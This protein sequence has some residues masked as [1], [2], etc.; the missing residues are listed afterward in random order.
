MPQSRF[1]SGRTAFTLVE[2]L[3]VISIIGV[4][5]ALLLPAVNAARMA[6]FRATCQ[7]RMKEIGKATQVYESSKRKFP[8]SLSWAEATR[9]P[10][11]AGADWRTLPWTV[12][13][14]P[15]LDQQKVY[16]DITYRNPDLS[17]PAN[18]NLIFIETFAC[19]ADADASEG[20]AL[21]YV[22]NVGR[23]DELDTATISASIPTLPRNLKANGIFHDAR[24]FPQHDTNMLYVTKGDGAANTL[25][26]TENKNASQWSDRNEFRMGVVWFDIANGAEY[27]SPTNPRPI[28]S[29]EAGDAPAD[30]SLSR[31][32]ANHADTFNNAFADGSVRPLGQEID[33]HVFYRLMTPRGSDV[34]VNALS[35]HPDFPTNPA[36]WQRVTINPQDMQP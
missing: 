15:N 27:N 20:P 34:Q 24:A 18:P 30:Y 8:S 33:E 32:S 7:N 25:L 12:R 4:L 16:D 22:A 28:N 3:V 36:N 31:P 26:Y 9:Q 23:P 21:S 6:A 5:M 13:L 29:G 1:R 10:G 11:S 2:L 14:F 35:G 17:L 19:Q